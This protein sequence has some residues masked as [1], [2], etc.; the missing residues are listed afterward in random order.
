MIINQEIVNG[1]WLEIKGEVQKVWGNITADE[2]EQTKG[3]V[4]SIAGIVLQK[5]GEEKEKFMDKFNLIVESLRTE[6]TAAIEN[7]KQTLK[8]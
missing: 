5:Y 8:G 4:N 2:I 3:D 6:K 7:V 1:K